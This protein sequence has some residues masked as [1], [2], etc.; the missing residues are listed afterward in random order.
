GNTAVVTVMSNFGFFRFAEEQGINTRT[1]KVGDRYVLE[2]MLA[3]GFSIGGEQSGHIIFSDYMNTGD[4][5]LSAIQLIAAM[6]SSGKKLSE[7]AHII[8]IMPQVL[9]NVEATR[10]MKAGINDSMELAHILRGCEARLEGRGRV[11]L[12]P[13]GTEPLIRVMVEGEELSELNEIANELAA[14]IKKYL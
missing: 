4:G 2:V 7:L 11:L 1:T 8:K 3:E 10:D 6:K 14:A 9:L 13:S 5:Q 12:R